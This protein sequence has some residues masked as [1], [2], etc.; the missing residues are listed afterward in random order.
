MS[1]RNSDPEK[2][3]NANEAINRPGGSK[4]DPGKEFIRFPNE[5]WQ[6]MKKQNREILDMLRR[7]RWN[8]SSDSSSSDS[9]DDYRNHKR[10][11]VVNEGRGRPQENENERRARNP[12]PPPAQPEPQNVQNHND[13]DNIDDD[14]QDQINR[15]MNADGND[16]PLDDLPQGDNV[17]LDDLQQ[18]YALDDEVGATINDNLASLLD[19]MAKGTMTEETLNRRFTTYKRPRNVSYDVPKVNMDVWAMMERSVKTRDLKSQRKQKIMLTAVN[20]LIK[21]AQVCVSNEATLTKRDTMHHISDAMGLIFKA[22]KEVSMDRR[23]SIVLSNNFDKKYRRLLS[24]DIP[25]THWLFGDDLKSTLSSIDQ[26]SK[27]SKAMGRIPKKHFN[28]FSKNGKRSFA[29]NRRSEERDQRRS[30]DGRTWYNQKTK[31]FAGKTK[32]HQEDQ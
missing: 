3:A 8:E 7:K 2:S 12:A 28:R 19:T 5:D 15:L 10:R 14:V 9:E 24:S 20:S 26:S 27:M 11:K 32:N 29:Y 13:D 25:V 30:K 16:N 31:K 21:V 17:N 1:D 18:E 4:D 22:S 6:A 23:A